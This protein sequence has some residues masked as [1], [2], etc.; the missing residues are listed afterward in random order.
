MPHPAIPPNQPAIVTVVSCQIDGCASEQ[1][2]FSTNLTTSP[3]S[4]HQAPP[5]RFPPEGSVRV[6]LVN[7]ANNARAEFLR[8]PAPV[9]TWGTALPAVKAPAKAPFLANQSLPANSTTQNSTKQDSTKQN[10]TGDRKL[11]QQSGESTDDTTLATVLANSFPWQGY[12][13]DLAAS[14]L[15]REATLKQLASRKKV[16]QAEPAPQPINQGVPPPASAQ[17]VP[18]SSIEIPAAPL[19]D[20]AVPAG[21]TLPATTE[22]PAVSPNPVTPP[23]QQPPQVPGTTPLPL[24]PGTVGVVEL[25]A[26]RQ[27][28]N[29]ERQVFTAEG[30]V[31]M[32]FQGALLDADRLQVNLVNRVAVAEGNVALTKGDQVLRGG[33]FEYNFVQGTGTVFNASGE[34]FI[35]TA[36]SD[37]TAPLSNDAV[38]GTVIGRPVSDRITANQPIQGISSTGGVVI[39]VGAGRDV[40]RVAG[41]SPLGGQVRRIRFEAEQIDFNQRVYEAK[42]IQITNDPFSPPELVLRAERAR[43]TRLNPFQDEVVATRPRLVFDQRLAIPTISRVV[44]DRRQRQPAVI[45]VGFD[46]GDRGGLFVSRAIE[47]IQSPTVNLTLTPEIFLQRIILDDGGV[48]NPASYG[49]R[50]K[51]DAILSPRTTINGKAKLTSL[52]PEDFDNRARASLRL[53]QSIGTHSLAV[54]A[55]YRDRLF[56]NSL[57]FQTVQSSLG[58]L[59]YS[60]VIALGKSGVNLTYQVG[61]QNITADTDR[62]D[63]LEPVRENDRINLSRFQ[64]ALAL[65]RGFLLWQGKPLPATPTEGVRYTP[66]PIVPYVS[67]FTGL[68]GVSSLYS[69]GDSQNNLIA[70]VGVGGQFGRMSRNFF[71]YTGFNVSYSQTIGRGLS[72][73]LF[74]RSVDTSI[75]S[76]GLVQQVY[77]PF[78][79]GFQT[80]INLNTNNEI[81]TDYILEYSRR[82]YGIIL[83]VN[84]VLE[85][86]SLNLRI[87]DFN[88]TG[89]TDPFEGSDITPVEGGIRRDT[90]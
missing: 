36:G 47:V 68:T 6:D 73:F 74:D 66:N 78:R 3:I 42:N 41:R 67:F 83:R 1:P 29:A 13:A 23:Q 9:L 52:D 38:R 15:D 28:Y 19:P 44:L 2:P 57:G 8:K 49:L 64:G 21:G 90:D 12:L 56:N 4:Q 22:T 18:P 59:F 35:P 14:G 72:P 51:F 71:D 54:E 61:F 20:G 40:N 7:Q 55:S 63:L 62:A 48:F 84:P 27:D 5:E 46:N 53:L 39:G 81:T 58:L 45:Q 43:L 70:T 17:P 26:D 79:V 88:W 86:G 87:S 82:T 50:A 11:P 16:A 75:L 37:A 65:S 33:R 31:K 69:N 89:G 85:I 32:R 10:Q 30:N 34:L 76:L 80:S 77:G 60:P 24:P 25:T